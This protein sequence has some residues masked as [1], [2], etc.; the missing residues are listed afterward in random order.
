MGNP[1]PE[2]DLQT[3]TNSKGAATTSAT[4]DTNTL[5][6]PLNELLAIQLPEELQASQQVKDVLLLLKMLEAINRY[7]AE[8]HVTRQGVL[9]Y[10]NSFGKQ[11]KEKPTQV[12]KLLMHQIQE[13]SLF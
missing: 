4:S 3:D 7:Q 11:Y 1:A 5:D 9:V 10:T 12:K 8:L 13:Q 2:A 6:S